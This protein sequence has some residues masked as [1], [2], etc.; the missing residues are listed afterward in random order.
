MLIE[1]IGPSL[2]PPKR[3]ISSELIYNEPVSNWGVGSL[4]FKIYHEFYPFDKRSIVVVGWYY[5]Y[6]FI[7]PPK[8]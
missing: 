8:Q 7:N 6:A 1:S 5:P 3:R 4:K 2:N